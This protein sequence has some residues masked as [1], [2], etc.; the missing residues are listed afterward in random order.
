LRLL[1]ALASASITCGKVRA[2]D[3]IISGGIQM[4]LCVGRYVHLF[5]MVFGLI[6]YGSELRTALG[7]VRLGIDMA[8]GNQNKKAGRR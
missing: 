4:P 3:H 2:N 7:L 1:F 8:A 5:D 6:K